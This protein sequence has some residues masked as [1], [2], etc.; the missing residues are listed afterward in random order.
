MRGPLA[1]VAEHRTFNP[2]VAGS[3]PARLTI[4]KFKQ[5]I[6][7]VPSSRGLGHR[8]FKAAARVRIPLG[9]PLYSCRPV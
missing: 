1:Q 2:G 7:A 6:E 5:F 9:P 3:N 4:T 8:P